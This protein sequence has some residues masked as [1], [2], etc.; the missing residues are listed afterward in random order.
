MTNP[1][2]ESSILKPKNAPIKP[3]IIENDI[4]ISYIFS[5]ASDS[6]KGD[7]ELFATIFRLI[8]TRIV[9]ICEIIKNMK[10]SDEKYNFFSI[11]VVKLEISLKASWIIL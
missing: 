8:A 7:F 5:F 1:K 4:K 2:I 9:M 10:I 6:I 11:P 3:K